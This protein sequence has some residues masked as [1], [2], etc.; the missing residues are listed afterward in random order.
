LDAPD[1]C[2]FLEDRGIL[3]RDRS[4]MACLAG[5][6]RVTVGEEEENRAFLEGLSAFRESRALIFDLDDTLVDTSK[7]YDAVLASLV[8]NIS[9]R[10]LDPA[11]LGALRGEGGFND[12]WDAGRE[13]L[14]RRGFP[15]SRERIEA[16]GKALYLSL[17]SEK[18]YL[19][20]DE[21]T[22]RRLSRRYRLFILTGRPRDEYAPVW[23]AALDPLFEGV[24]CRDDDPQSRP[25]PAP[26]HL[27][28]LL[29]TNGVTSGTYVGNSVDDMSAARAAGLRPV[30]VAT[31][32]KE[33]TLRDAGAET[34]LEGPGDIGEVFM[35]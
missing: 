24:V 33:E 28:K 13:I 11:E 15:V 3:I 1:L 10:P 2:S 20:V 30:A 14:V 19:L 34:V 7:S 26:D 21:G 5:A 8:E 29:R 16:E 32:M 25:K 4:A 22:L 23:G 12:D 6:V 31:T 27:V 17:A 9:G 18:E 35:P